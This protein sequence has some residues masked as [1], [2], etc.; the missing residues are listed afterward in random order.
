MNTVI[1]MSRL[2]APTLKEAPAEAELASHVL[3]LRAGMIRKNAAGIYTFLPLGQRV[4]RKV[5]QIVREEMDAIGSQEIMMPALQPAE[6]WHE[7]GRWDDY[8]PELMRLLDRH[9]RG[10]CLGPTHE[11]LITSIVRNELRSYKDLPRSLYQIQVKFRDE[12][13]PR[14]GLLRSREFIM[15]D[16]YSFHVDQDSLQEHYDEMSGAYGRICE[17]CGLEYRPVDAD[18]GQIGG[19]VSTE[20]MALAENGEADLVYCDCGFAADVEAAT[21]RIEVIPSVDTGIELVHTPGIPTIAMLAEFM[22]VPEKATVKALSGK[23]GDGNVIVLFIPGDHELN[24]IKACNA[25]PGFDLLTDEEMLQAGLVKGFMGPVG[26]PEGVKVYADESLKASP[27]WLVG[28]NK[29]DYHYKGA[30]MGEDFSVDVWA[31]LCEIRYE[32]GCPLCGKPL[33]HA[34]GIEVSQVFQLGT[35]YSEAMGATYMAEDGEERPFVMGCYGVGVSRTMAA[36]VEQYNDEFGIQWPISVAPY[37]VAV[38]PLVT[39]DD[40]VEPVAERIAAELAE[41]GVETVIDDRP[42]RAGVKFNDADLYGWPYQ[43]VCGKRGVKNGNVELKVRATNEKVDVA[44]DEVVDM[45]VARITEER[46]R[47]THEAVTG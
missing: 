15:K 2:Y 43:V 19:S 17:R 34:R 45:L 16:A 27:Y 37:E 38:L 21:G 4:L 44:I 12:I 31:D 5:G 14:F 20:Y 24:D 41:R 18:S 13:R 29:V 28:A 6:L 46:A 30:K 40:L 47:Y 36:I 7:S 35:K 3:L 8:G 25:I 42:E 22:G 32:D 23:D 33:E 11:E 9:D 1:R 10:F 26:L 39:G